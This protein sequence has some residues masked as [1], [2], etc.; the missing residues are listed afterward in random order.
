MRVN[1]PADHW[2]KKIAKK[3]TLS[4][5]DIHEVSLEI[6]HIDSLKAVSVSTIL[7][8]HMFSEKLPSKVVSQCEKYGI[9]TIGKLQ[10]AHDDA[11]LRQA[12]ILSYIPQAICWA[13]FQR[14]F[15]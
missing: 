4:P 3:G 15:L 9:N 14:V 6:D 13:L 2:K 10:Y 5:G 11:G 7:L 8:Q 1:I 12:L